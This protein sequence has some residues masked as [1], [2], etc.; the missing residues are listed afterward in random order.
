MRRG[1]EKGA[2]RRGTTGKPFDEPTT[3]KAPALT[4]CVPAGAHGV[5]ALD[6]IADTPFARLLADRLAGTQRKRFIPGLNLLYISAMTSERPLTGAPRIAAYLKT[7]PDAPGV[8]RMLNAAGEVLYVGKAK[9][10]RKRVSSYA[11]GAVT[12]NGS[13]A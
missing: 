12:A 2:A 10:L 11:K 4:G 8:Y 13:P 9:S 5:P 3:Q 6:R 1:Q 7:L